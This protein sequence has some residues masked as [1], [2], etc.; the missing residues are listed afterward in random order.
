MSIRRLFVPLLVT[1][2]ASLA[3]AACD[4][5][6]QRGSLVWADLSADEIGAV[7]SASLDSEGMDSRYWE[8]ESDAE[9]GCP[10]MTVVD[11]DTRVYEATTTCFAGSGRAYSGRVEITRHRGADEGSADLLR[12]MRFTEFQF[13]RDGQATGLDGTIERTFDPDSHE[14]TFTAHLSVFRDGQALWVDLH[15]RCEGGS[16]GHSAGSRIELVGRGDYYVGFIPS[17]GDFDDGS[18]V[19]RGADELVVEL[20]EYPDGCPPYTIDGEPAGRICR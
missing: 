3:A 11:A 19:Y 10:S 15:R 1:I 5:E 14:Q 6:V 12:E 18:M 16:C 20:Y 17:R 13:L 7:V 8:I 4:G 2:A 9:S